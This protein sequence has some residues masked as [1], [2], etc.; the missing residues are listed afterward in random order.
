MQMLLMFSALWQDTE[1][2]TADITLGDTLTARAKARCANA[3]SAERVQKTAEAAITLAT[4]SLRSMST[5]EAVPNTG[6][7]VYVATKLLS[8]LKMNRDDQLVTASAETPID[9]LAMLAPLVPAFTNAREQARRTQSTNEM[10]QL[11]LAFHNY[12]D[13][14]KRF[15]AAAMLG[16]D[17]KTLH[18]WRVAI[19]PYLDPRFKKL[20]EQY[21]LDEPWDSENN[22]QVL[23]QMPAIFRSPN[24]DPKSVNAS[25]F[26]VTGPQTIF[27]DNV[28]TS[29]RQITDGTSNTILLVE[30]KRDIPWTKPEDIDVAV[31]KP[32]PAIG[33]PGNPPI[34]A[35]ADGSVRTFEPKIEGGKPVPISEETLRALFTRAGKE[36]F[37]R[38]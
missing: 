4:N 8:L 22:K 17:G 21:K 15:P 7:A 14:H 30:A 23:A 10:K 37:A 32:L 34:V 11:A 2:L 38:P 26:A 31:D 28:G 5:P 33:W 36:I 1:T 20:Y 6:R 27:H 16:P 3:E 29:M 9:S 24:D 19:L 13:A 12:A 25:F 18:S 35:F